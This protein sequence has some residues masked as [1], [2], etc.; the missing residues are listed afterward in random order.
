MEEDI[1]Q[2]YKNFSVTATTAEQSVTFPQAVKYLKVKNTGG[3]AVTI[4][5]ITDKETGHTTT[6]VDKFIDLIAGQTTFIDTFE[7]EISVIT[8]NYK[9]AS[10]TSAMQIYGSW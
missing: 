8:V 10:S 5:L 3:Q 4:V 2:R 9:S 6:T 1:K 7:D